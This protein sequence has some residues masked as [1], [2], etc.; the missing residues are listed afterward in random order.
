MAKSQSSLDRITRM[1]L[2]LSSVGSVFSIA[3]TMF[4]IGI[5]VF[6]AFFS[7][8]YFQDLSQ[9]VEVEILFY[10][11]VKESDIMAFEQ[12]LK[13]EPY[14]SQSRFCSKADNTAEAIKA[15]GNDFT[16]IITNPINASILL[17]VTPEYANGDSLK[18]ITKK[19]KQNPNVQD[20]EYP[21]S[22]VKAILD[23]FIKVQVVIVIVCAVFMLISMLLIGNSL[24]LAIYSKRFS[25]RS[26]LLIG[27]TRSFVRK[28]FLIKGLVQGIWGGFI[29]CVLVALTLWEGNIVLPEFIDFQYIK[30]VA[31]LLGGLFVF[32]V[33]FTLVISLFSVNKY[34]K[35]NRD[36]LYL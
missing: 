15:I 17:S 8:K 30:H 31:M 20:V 3:L 21:E 34:I 36:A 29:A 19:L 6:F 35:I 26:M 23:N 4:F 12:R 16:E 33:V 27:A 7:M 28:P 24:R 13:T 22:I 1:R 32:S 9:K 18:V 25:I 10:S 11:D 2:F 14:I 5:L